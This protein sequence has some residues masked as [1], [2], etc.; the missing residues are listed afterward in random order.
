M[1]EMTLKLSRPADVVAALR[2]HRRG[3]ATKAARIP[4]RLAIDLLA[5]GAITLARAASLARM[6]RAEKA[7][8]R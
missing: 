7:D 1:P 3:E 2:G 5:E 8:G 4:S 6:N